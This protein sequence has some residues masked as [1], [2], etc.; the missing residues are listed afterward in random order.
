MLRFVLLTLTLALTHSS[1]PLLQ[2]NMTPLVI[3]SCVDC[4]AAV[5]LLLELPE[6]DVNFQDDEVSITVCPCLDCTVLM[7]LSVF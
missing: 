1:D 3:V 7:L 2:R 4:T 5:K 6:V